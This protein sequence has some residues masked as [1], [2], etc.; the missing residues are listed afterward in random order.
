MRNNVD[1]IRSL[2]IAAKIAVN[3]E[4]LAEAREDILAFEKWVETLL[5]VETEGVEPTF[6]SFFGSN[7]PREDVA[8]TQENREKFFRAA[9]NFVEGFYR[10][11]PIIE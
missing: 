3:E 1:E 4:K 7:I 9:S 10:V 8:I 11:P 5:E 6:Y 2:F